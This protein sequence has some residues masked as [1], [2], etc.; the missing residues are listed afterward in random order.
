VE[1]L[2]DLKTQL[3]NVTV[4]LLAVSFLGSAVSWTSDRSILYFGA[5]IGI[6]IIALAG[7]SIAH[8]RI[9]HDSASHTENDA[10]S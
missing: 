1:S 7:Y 6:V 5:G 3:L 2:N 8:H 9:E 4:V 10:A